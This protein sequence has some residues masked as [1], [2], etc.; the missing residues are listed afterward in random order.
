[1]FSNQLS[2]QASVL[3]VD[4]DP[5]VRRLLERALRDGG[6]LPRPA[7]DIVSAKELLEAGASAVVLDMLFVNSAGLS[8][9]DL[10]RYI[11]ADPRYK[12]LP[13]ILLTGF[14]LNDAVVREVKSLGALLC[15]KPVSP[16]ALVDRLKELVSLNLCF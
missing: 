15:Q 3:V 4:D 6:F 10:L 1:M 16:L 9:L 11:R 14:T 8:G 5:S 13:V 2:Q 12:H 7:M